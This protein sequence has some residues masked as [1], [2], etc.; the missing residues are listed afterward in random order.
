MAILNTKRSRT[1]K[2]ILYYFTILIVFSVVTSGI[3]ILTPQVESNTGGPDTHGYRWIDSKGTTN[4]TYN[5]TDGVTGGMNLMLTDQDNSGPI[6]IGF[7]FPFYSKSYSVIYICDN[8]WASFIHSS[9][10]TKDTIPSQFHPN[11]V[12]AP[13]WLDLDPAMY[14]GTGNV[15][16]K[17]MNQ[18]TPKHFIIT[19]DSLPIYT[20]SSSYDYNNT[21]QAIIYENGSVLFQYKAINTT[22]THIPI[23][24]IENANGNIGLQY[25]ATLTNESAVMFYYDYPE[26]ELKVV[27]L[28]MP[29]VGVLNEDMQIGASIQNFGLTDEKDVNVTLKINSAVVNWTLM[30]LN[31]FQ[32]KPIMFT[33]RPTQSLN[34]SVEI[35]VVPV[36]NETNVNNNK[37]S[38]NMDVRNWRLV[39]LDQSQGEWMDKGYFSDWFDELLKH[40]FYVEEFHSGTITSSLLDR[41]DIVIF[42]TP[43]HSFAT[44]ELTAIHNFVNSG[45]GMLVFGYYD[46]YTGVY[47]SLT[48]P[49]EISWVNYNWGSGTTNL[50]AKH[51]ITTNVTSI[52]INTA[53]NELLVTGAAKALVWDSSVTPNGIMLAISNEST[54]GRVVGY[55]DPYGFV[56]W[57]INMANNKVMAVQLMEWLMEDVKPPARPRGFKVT[58]GKVGNQL[59]LSWTANTE[60]D[61][62]GYYVYR[63][64][65]TV[66]YTST[67][68]AVVPSDKSSYYDTNLQDHTKYYYKI[69]A[70]DEVPNISEFS[71]EVSGTP[72]DV[73]APGIVQNFTVTDVGTGF[74]LNLTWNANTE[75][76]I[77]SY[78][79]YKSTSVDEPITEPYQVLSPDAVFY[80]DTEVIEGE[81]YYYM[82]SAVDEVP[83]ESELTVLRSAIPFDRLAPKQPTNFNVSNPGIGNALTLRWD[84]N[85]END[86]KDYLIERIDHKGLTKYFSVKPTANTFQDS[87]LVDGKTYSYRVYARDDTKLPTPN[88]SPPT[89][90]KKNIPTDVTPPGQPQNFTIIDESYSTEYEQFQCLNLTWK[91]GN[92]SDLRG[93][94]VYKFTASSWEPTE[95]QF[96]VELGITDHYLDYDVVEE[97]NYWYKITAFDEVPN[98][99]PPSAELKGKARDVTPPPVPT[100]FKAEPMPKGNS[101]ILTWEL[102]ENLD[103]DGGYRIYY[104]MN[105]TGEFE[106]V[107]EFVYNV[108]YYEHE[109]LIDDQQYF[110]KL[111]AFD[112]EPNYSP[113]TP[114]ITVIP[115]DLEPPDPPKGLRIIPIETGNTLQLSWKESSDEDLNGYR[116]YR[117][118]DDLPYSMVMAVD[119]N[120]TS[121]IDSYL[122]DDKTYRYY[123]TALDE[124]PNESEGSVEK[125]ALPKDTI[126]PEPVSEVTI[127]LTTGKD[128]VI[129]SWTPSTSNDAETYRIFRST[130]GKNFKKLIDVPFTDKSYTDS[131]V[132]NDRKYYYQLTALDEVPNISPRSDVVSIRVPTEKNTLDTGLITNSIIAIIII[133]ILLA[134]LL[135]VIRKLGKKGEPEKQKEEGK[136]GV[137]VKAKGEE[138]PTGAAEPLALAPTIATITRSQT[139][140]TP[141]ATTITGPSL[142]S[143]AAGTGALGPPTEPPLLKPAPRGEIGQAP[144]TKRTE[145]LTPATISESEQEVTES[146]RPIPGYPAKEKSLED[147]ER[148]EE[149]QEIVTKDITAMAPPS[150]PAP[151][152]APAPA[153]VPRPTMITKSVTIPT[154]SQG[155][156]SLI[157]PT[158][159]LPTILIPLDAQGNEM[160]PTTEAKGKKKAKEPVTFLN[161]DL[162]AVPRRKLTKPPVGKI[163]TPEAQEQTKIKTKP[164]KRPLKEPLRKP[165]E[166][167][168]TREMLKKKPIKIPEEK[169][170]E[171]S[172]DK[173][174]VEQ[175]SEEPKK[176]PKNA[177]DEGEETSEDD[178]KK[179]LEQ[180]MK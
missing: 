141:T 77:E 30:D 71:V 53:R 20:P 26:H 105:K 16:Y 42:P 22:T 134:V 130:D 67:P 27:D 110:Y 128:S 78:N 146:K 29:D 21:F 7:T 31:S 103:Q 1:N 135:L 3:L 55:V 131:A 87:N 169:S 86:L 136:A 60:K 174:K 153:Q 46:Y 63:K 133:V 37:L 10:T 34:Y 11:A 15:Y 59:N 154:T 122:V 143:G 118:T 148:A 163:V 159:R 151:A 32:E 126:A 125:E 106:L 97:K 23:I 102:L 123:I 171:K 73:I 69:A 165:V 65:D 166:K 84:K 66:D 62:N 158:K 50:V 13:F 52:Y 19:W 129:L 173:T 124:V 56:D 121:V 88:R 175:P 116:V 36:T 138:K 89:P 96:L 18:S 172:K 155:R 162:Y 93:Y 35:A 99:S 108:N 140:K 76:D 109:G 54:P 68:I 157:Q 152:P 17:R 44:S 145:P 5:W 24:G 43:S 177:E 57:S 149:A 180:Y 132:E 115:S 167:V 101:V 112:E 98:E 100:G 150:P 39:M 72:T 147:Q 58:N 47:N 139:P 51:E 9:T 40:N 168:K 80:Q 6:P 49:Y 4:I 127:E 178:I 74:E 117:Q 176:K 156:I 70:I 91:I 64:T 170:K 160:I 75:P 114:L 82:I 83:N 95:D 45:H 12:I 179:I 90:W 144:E 111:Q 8:G 14:V 119:K 33:W 61:L 142:G 2:S 104:S 92:E 79:L 81:S 161:P 38:R 94:K 113:F 25:S 85:P 48:Q 164:Q 120:T 137:E 41:Y 107:D 28:I